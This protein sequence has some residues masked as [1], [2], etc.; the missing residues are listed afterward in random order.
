MAE[1]SF[2][3][4][5]PFSIINLRPVYVLYRCGQLMGLRY[6]NFPSY[7]HQLIMDLFMAACAHKVKLLAT[8][9]LHAGITTPQGT[10]FL[11][12]MICKHPVCIINDSLWCLNIQ[13]L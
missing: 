13:W 6:T 7:Y 12:H 2:H 10:T 1:L 5:T 3:Y 11:L 9:Y 4:S 8:R